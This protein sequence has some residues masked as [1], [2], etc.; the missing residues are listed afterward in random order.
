MRRVSIY[1][2]N[3][4]YYLA[5]SNILKKSIFVT[6]TDRVHA[7]TD[8]TTTECL[9][10]ILSDGN[11]FECIDL[12]YKNFVS[13]DD[14]KI[15]TSGSKN[16][17]NIF[18]AITGRKFS[19]IYISVS[20]DELTHFLRRVVN[21]CL[22]PDNSPPKNVITENEYEIIR[23][24]SM[25]FSVTEIAAMKEKSVK[26]ISSHKC[27][28]FRKLGLKNSKRNLLKLTHDS[29]FYFDR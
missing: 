6:F 10:L 20:I 4:F 11:L 21:R 23:L 12:Y 16:V 18:N 24:I 14:I 13:R 29:G 9:V 22:F 3:V 2:D 26:T 8:F 5:F 28:F 17:V 15:I 25:G 7:R 27:S 19:S 1:C